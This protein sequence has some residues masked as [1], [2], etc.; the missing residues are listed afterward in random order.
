MSLIETFP[1]EENEISS[2]VTQNIK[3]MESQFIS[4]IMDAF[5][6][7]PVDQMDCNGKIIYLGFDSI[8][9]KNWKSQDFHS[10][11]DKSPVIFLDY[12]KQISLNNKDLVSKFRNFVGKDFF[13][14]C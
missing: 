2:L 13:S 7:T 10:I 14:K 6:N 12:V 11:C 5:S 1:V 8:E 3:I 9:F 4:N